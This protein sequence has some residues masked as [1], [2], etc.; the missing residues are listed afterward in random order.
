MLLALGFI[1]VYATAKLQGI[2]RNA[3][4]LFWFVKE[5]LVR[6]DGLTLIDDHANQQKLRAS[7]NKKKINKHT[8]LLNII[9]QR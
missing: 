3:I 9:K 5:I 7:Y 6:F 4:S 8:Q 2:S 1:I